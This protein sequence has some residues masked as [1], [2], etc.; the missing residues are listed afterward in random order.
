MM[1]V[2]GALTAK[3]EGSEKN[4]KKVDD[5]QK[6][7]ARYRKQFH[8]VVGLSEI[9]A[10]FEQG[11][12]DDIPDINEIDWTFGLSETLPGLNNLMTIQGPIDFVRGFVN[13]T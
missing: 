2:G 10:E 11:G 1:H 13:G 12:A 5:F 3:Y 6:F 4:Q 7:K 8:P 9:D